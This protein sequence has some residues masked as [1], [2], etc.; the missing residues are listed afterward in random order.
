[1]G[2]EWEGMFRILAAVAGITCILLAAAVRFWHNDDLVAAALLLV[3]ASIVDVLVIQ[4]LLSWHQCVPVAPWF[5]YGDDGDGEWEIVRGLQTRQ[6]DVAG[7]PDR[8][9]INPLPDFSAPAD[10]PSR[11][12]NLHFTFEAPVGLFTGIQV[13]S[14]QAPTYDIAQTMIEARYKTKCLTVPVRVAD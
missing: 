14:V 1:M 13:V 4:W 12:Y 3:V 10:T 6:L 8:R 11:G 5:E 7:I 9:Q 2:R